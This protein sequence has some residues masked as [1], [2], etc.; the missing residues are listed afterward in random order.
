VVFS[1]VGKDRFGD[2]LSAELDRAKVV[3][4]FVQRDPE[5]PTG[6]VISL[7]DREGER[8]MITVPGA[9]SALGLERLD[10]AM[11]DIEWAYLS[12]YVARRCPEVAQRVRSQARERRIPISLDLN[13]LF[14]S[15]ELEAFGPEGLDL[16]L[17]TAREFQR[18]PDGVEVFVKRGAA[19]C[20]WHC[21][22]A[23]AEVPGF[24]VAGRD[25]TGAGD[26]F[27]AG[28]IAA[29]L[30][31]YPPRLQGLLGNL[32]GALCAAGHR[33]PEVPADAVEGLLGG[34]DISREERSA[35]REFLRRE[36]T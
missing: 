7:V 23:S 17:G 14:T 29:R 30:R 8:T 11:G 22:A 15:E 31:G 34:A 20:V 27:V 12:G 13:P 10:E 9:N 1:R 16:I 26:A 21:S 33:P 2:V 5:R 24:A 36:R 28:V 6:M 25:T 19:G 18:F 3:T 35:I 4:E 32:C